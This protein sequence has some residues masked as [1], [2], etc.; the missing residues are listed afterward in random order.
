MEP[1]LRLM[2]YQVQVPGVDGVEVRGGEVRATALSVS[3]RGTDIPH[4]QRY[5]Y[6]TIYV[7]LQLSIID[8]YCQGR[9]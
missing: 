1:S 5:Q 9:G 6:Y 3:E 2:L 4:T 8:W 7:Y